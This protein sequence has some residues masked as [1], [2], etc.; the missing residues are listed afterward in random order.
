MPTN[1]VNSVVAVSLEKDS[2]HSNSKERQCQRIFKLHNCTHFTC[3]KGHAQNPLRQVSTV[4]ELRITD[5][6]SGF[7]KG[8]RSRDQIASIHWIIEKTWEFQKIMHFCFTD[9]TK[10]FD[11]V[12]HNKLWK[13]LK[14]TVNQTTF[15][16]CLLRNL[17]S[18]Q[19]ATIRTGHR[20][21]DW[22]KIEKGVRQGCM[23]SPCLF[24]F[25]AKYI[26]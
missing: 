9:Y 5:V 4:P 7:R 3:Q 1:L 19:E 16:T 11:C 25:Y 10:A 15:L 22:F 17:Y 18:G 14:E 20:T 21:M 2:L 12:Y 23:L 6:Q 8:R 13:I 24:N 26:M